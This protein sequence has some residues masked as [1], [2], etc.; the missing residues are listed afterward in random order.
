MKVEGISRWRSA[1]IITGHDGRFCQ[2]GNNFLQNLSVL[3][4]GCK[5]ESAMSRWMEEFHD[6]E[7][8]L[9]DAPFRLR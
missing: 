2:V 5:Q 3:G 9:I 7:G 8:Q 4:A 1:G 6:V